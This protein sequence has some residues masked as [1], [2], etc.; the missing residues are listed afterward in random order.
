MLGRLSPLLLVATAG[1]VRRTGLRME[2]QGRQ[3]R[4]APW[5]SVGLGCRATHLIFPA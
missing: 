1:G 4:P 3:G 2:H 5:P